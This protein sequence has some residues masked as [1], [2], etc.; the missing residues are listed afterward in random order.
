M[1]ELTVIRDLAAIAGVI[2]GLSYYILTIRNQNKA[3]QTV[4][5]IQLHQHKTSPE[6]NTRFWKLLALKWEDHD[7]YQKKYGP[8]GSPDEEQTRSMVSAEWGFYEGLGFMLKKGLVDL[9]TV[10]SLFGVRCTMMWYK[11]ETLIDGV[12]S[13]ENFGGGSRIYENFEY[14]ANEIIKMNGKYG[15]PVPLDLVHPKTTRY[16]DL[17]Q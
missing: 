3:R 11:Y 2:I 5:I 12:R 9:E 17:I 14:L 7:D 13:M 6:E 1:V 15:H 16:R 10:Y 8:L 4:A